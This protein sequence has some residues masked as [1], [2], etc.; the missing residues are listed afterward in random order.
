MKKNIFLLMHAA[1]YSSSRISK[2]CIGGS[3]EIQILKKKKRKIAG[4]ASLLITTVPVK[5][6]DWT[7]L[8][9]FLIH[10]RRVWQFIPAVIEWKPGYTMASPS[11]G[12]H[13]ETENHSGSHSHHIN[14]QLPWRTCTPKRHTQKALIQPVN[15]SLPA[16]ML[17][18]WPL[19]RCAKPVFT[20]FTL[21]IFTYLSWSHCG[22]LLHTAVIYSSISFSSVSV[23]VPP[24]TYHECGTWSKLM[25]IKKTQSVI[26]ATSQVLH[27]RWQ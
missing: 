26:K 17:K 19:D 5:K 22:S 27:W 11:Q 18:S 6:M 7:L 15:S 16:V 4:D 21:F 13:M 10:C 25:L 3:H 8:T 1:S 23:S 24:N 9:A 12:W 20:L 14:H 2:I